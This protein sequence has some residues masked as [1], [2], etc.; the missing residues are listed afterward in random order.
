MCSGNLEGSVNPWYRFGRR[1]GIRHK[2]TLTTEIYDLALHSKF[3][4]H[5]FTLPLKKW[6]IHNELS[7]EFAL[8]DIPANPQERV[9][10][11]DRHF[12]QQILQRLFNNNLQDECHDA[13][14]FLPNSDSENNVKAWFPYDLDVTGLLSKEEVLTI[15]HDVDHATRTED[16]CD[17]AVYNLAVDSFNHLRLFDF[18]YDYA[19]GREKRP[20]GLVTCLHYI[21]TKVD[22]FANVSAYQ[23]PTTKRPWYYWSWC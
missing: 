9:Y 18:G 21:L 20:L 5:P 1:S 3:G 15:S 19:V 22:H 14:H 6:L 23:D 4:T 16:T 17:I 13:M 8:R 7:F 12:C 11:L 10:R 2:H